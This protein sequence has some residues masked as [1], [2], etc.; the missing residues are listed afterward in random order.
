MDHLNN[1]KQ[2]NNLRESR[3]I[4]IPQDSLM[5]TCKNLAAGILLGHLTLKQSFKKYLILNKVLGY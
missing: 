5:V 3:H 4:N 2:E 1:T